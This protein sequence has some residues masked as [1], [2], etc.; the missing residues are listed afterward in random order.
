MPEPARVSATRRPISPTEYE[1]VW[2]LISVPRNGWTADELYRICFKGR[3]DQG[4]HT[5]QGIAARCKSLADRGW[6]TYT[7]R[8]GPRQYF[9]TDKAREAVSW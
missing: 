3:H 9:A 7:N 8:K 6:L 5:T 2:R 4:W 1:I